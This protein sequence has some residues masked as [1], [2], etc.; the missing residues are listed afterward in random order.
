MTDHIPFEIQEQIMKR[1]P[2]K[3]LIQFKMVSK[4]WKSLI[5]SSEFMADYNLSQ[6][7]PNQLFIRY[8]K[9]S[10]ELKYVS[11]LDNNTF[12]Q[13]RF[14]HSV[15]E[16]FKLL[17][18]KPRVVGSSHGLFCLYGEYPSELSGSYPDGNSMLIIIW[19]PSI[20]KSIALDVAVRY[21]LFT[22][23]IGFGVHPDT[24]DPVIL[25]INDFIPSFEVFRLSTGVWTILRSNLPHESME[26]TLDG[27]VDVDGFMYWITWYKGASLIVSF[28]MIT[29]KFT[30]V[31][32]PKCLSSKYFS[33]SKLR[34]SLAVLEYFKEA[35]AHVCAAWM[36]MEDGVQK[37]FTKLY[38][39]STQVALLNTVPGFRNCGK[40]I[41]GTR[42]TV[43]D[44]EHE[45]EEPVSLS[46]YEPHSENIDGLEICGTP[47]F[48]L[49]VGSY[50]ESLLLLDHPDNHGK[51]VRT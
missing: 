27:Q 29:E 6:S 21:D 43:V 46:V 3:T 31:K 42:T 44:E 10:E 49:F 26:F 51:P 38:T 9:R 8:G 28:D 13:H 37:S 24:L 40:P 39:V 17:I 11:I 7:G 50:T 15:P 14:V 45:Y 25:K 16:S 4:P 1:L 23:L 36:M 35:E 12:P 48:C 19:N 5:E 33:L 18:R 47:P 2:V 41:V 22:S 32:F 30:E 34:E 20:N